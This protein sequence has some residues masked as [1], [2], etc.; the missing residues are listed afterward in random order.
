MEKILSQ[1]LDK[2]NDKEIELNKTY[3]VSEWSWNPMR[4]GY[5]VDQETIRYVEEIDGVKVYTTG[6]NHRHYYAWD[7]YDDFDKA[8]IMTKYKNSY[9]YDWSDID[10]HI[11]FSQLSYTPDKI[12][13]IIGYDD[14]D[15][16]AIENGGS[17]SIKGN[18]EIKDSDRERIFKRLLE[19]REK[20]KGE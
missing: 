10:N 11:K 4:D 16:E 9:G 5:I 18:F 6:L 13:R 19:I 1:L 17:F 2:Y 7:L 12:V 20:F 8:V 3:Y 15:W 14:I